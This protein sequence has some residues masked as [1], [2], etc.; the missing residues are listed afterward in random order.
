[1]EGAILCSEHF[2]H[3]VNR[4]EKQNSLPKPSPYSLTD[5]PPGLITGSFLFKI[6]LNILLFDA[7][8]SDS[9]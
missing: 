5:P 4:E 1:M 6:F 8:L 9:E 7:F 3:F 2:Q